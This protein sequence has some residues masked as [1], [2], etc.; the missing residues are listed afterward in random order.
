MADGSWLIA[1]SK[2][3]WG[4]LP[5]MNHLGSMGKEKRTTKTQRAQRKKISWF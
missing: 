5:E 1:I 3:K 4:L 2:V